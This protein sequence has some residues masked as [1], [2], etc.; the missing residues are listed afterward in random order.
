MRIY[1][2]A[3][4]KGGVGKSTIA[5]HLSWHLKERGDR[6]LH[7][8]LDP[9]NNSGA[10]LKTHA[11]SGVKQVENAAPVE[12][13]AITSSMLFEWPPVEVSPHQSGLTVVPADKKLLDLERADMSTINSFCDS[14]ELQGERVDAAGQPIFTT[15][16]IDTGPT[17]GLKLS[18]ALIA[19]T[20]VVSPIEL[21]GYSIQGIQDLLRTILGI[22]SRFNE[23]LNF[24]GL[25]ANRFNAVNPLQ[26]QALEDLLSKFPQH[27]IPTK[28]PTRT[29]ISDAI[30][31]GL[32]V[33]AIK[34]GRDPGREMK[35]AMEL[36][37]ERG[38]KAGSQA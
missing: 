14:L 32:P 26:R 22:K 25:L 17:A 35:Q 13:S 18:A 1:V 38:S 33:W 6:V 4:Q 21:E 36:L 2:I 30:A 24:I 29:A 11:A 10:T 20:D 31:Q 7:I 28:I 34:G 27:M 37:I 3:N 8:D 9:Q 15:C 5:C 16:V 23:K 12:V 19:A